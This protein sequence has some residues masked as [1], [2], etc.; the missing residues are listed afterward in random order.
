MEIR[1]FSKQTA[2]A[3]GAAA[4]S[5]L[6]LAG[7]YGKALPD[8][9]NVGSGGE[10]T[11]NTFFT[12]SSRPAKN[13]CTVALTDMSAGGSHS[14]EN[15]LLLFGSVP[16]KDVTAV[17]EPRPQLVPCGE[18]F[19]IKLLTDGVV[20]VELTKVGDSCPARECGIRKG[21]I[22]VSIDGKNI[23]SNRDVSAAVR[24]CCEGGCT[25]RLRRGGKDMTLTIFPVWWEGSY[26]AGMWV[27]DSSAGIG[28]LTFYDEDTG[29][30]GG[31]GHPVCDSDT[32]EM[33]PLSE[34]AVGSIGITGL[35]PSSEGCP[36]QL[37]GEFKGDEVLGDI[38]LN[39]EQGLF[40]RLEAPPDKKEAVELGYKQEI[41]KGPAEIYSSLDG[42]EP[43]AYSVEIEHI[44]LSDSA[45]HD[46]V[47]HITDRELIGETGGIVQ[48]MSGSP[49]I[50]NGRL[51]GA[52]THVFI[53]DPTRGYGIFAED[54]AE[55]AL[56][57]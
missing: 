3:F 5:L 19:G 33:L 43:R 10:L 29:I 4:L 41:R 22:I 18:T 32:K 7:F 17:S 11:L 53:D 28:T 50:Q 27:R 35:I 45:P 57:S 48:G 23:R 20:V 49:I 2:A 51:V 31:L 46:L 6:G 16:V 25:V 24:E 39:C 40:G 9:Y 13:I 21:D 36:G 56:T 37:L 1:K 44:D 34:G 26:K 15:T 8:R 47:V 14:S 42:G 52:V 55:A 30:F 38:T 12:I 54:M